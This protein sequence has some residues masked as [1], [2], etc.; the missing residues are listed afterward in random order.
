MRWSRF[1][2]ALVVLALGAGAAWWVL[3]DRGPSDG[4]LVL[5]GTVDIRQVNLAF[6]VGGRIATMVADEG[7]RVAAGEQLAT[8]DRHAFEDE[9]RAAQ[10]RVDAQRARL[11]QLRAGPR[12]AELAVADADIAEAELA[13]RNTQA[14]LDREYDRARREAVA[15]IDLDALRGAVAEATARLDARRRFGE[16]TRSGPRTEEIDAAE[17]RLRADE[18]ELARVNGRLSET[19]LLAPAPGIVLTRAAEPGAVVPPGTPVYTLALISP[20]WV[21]AYAAES[22]LSR[23]QPGTRAE[24]TVTGMSNRTFVG[25]VAFVSPVAEFEPRGDRSGSRR[26]AYRLRV[27]VEDVDEELHQGVPVTVTFP[28]PGAGA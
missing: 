5:A 1:V 26:M 3:R 22:E 7:Q 13:V 28:P 25:H 27:V 17:A 15:P 19:E 2:V 12:P 14:A 6:N 24:I 23:V 11:T 21:R 8:L 10:S 16:L 18:A 20:V 4:S 9:W